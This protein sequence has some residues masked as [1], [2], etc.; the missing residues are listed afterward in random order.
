MK[1]FLINEP[2]EIYSKYAGCL[3]NLNN[4]KQKPIAQSVKDF[5]SS[6]LFSKRLTIIQL[7]VKSDKYDN[8]YLAYLLYDLLSNDAN[9]AVDTQEQVALFDSLPWSIKQCFKIAMK[10]TVQ[11]TNDLANFDIQ[12]IP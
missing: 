5:V 8:Q 11:Y 9:G 10:N 4:I 7:L 12:K 3:S 2:H 6:D 1:D